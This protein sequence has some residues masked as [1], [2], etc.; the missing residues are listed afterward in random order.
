ML[1]ICEMTCRW[2]LENETLLELDKSCI[3]CAAKVE[4][5]PGETSLW[6]LGLEES[7]RV[8]ENVQHSLQWFQLNRLMGLTIDHFNFLFLEIHN[9]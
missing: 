8:I 6:T 3:A 4:L 9:S 2:K 1:L 7:N 5:G